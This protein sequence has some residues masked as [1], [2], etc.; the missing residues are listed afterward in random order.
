M[1]DGSVPGGE[2]RTQTGVRNGSGP[3]L[4]PVVSTRER[5]RLGLSI[6]VAGC[7]LSDHAG[8]LERIEA[9]GYTDLWTQETDGH[10]A[11]T[12]LAFA[13]ARTRQV[14]LGSAIAS[15]STRGPALLAMQAAALADA[16]PGRF[17]LGIGTSSPTIVSGWNGLPFER[18]VAR[19]RATLRFLRRT[20][21]GE[22]VDFDEGDV[23]VRGFRLERP[24]APP[25]P[26]FLAAL[27]PQMLGL[28]AR[29]A[30]GVL[31]SLVGPDDVAKIRAARVAANPAARDHELA[32][33][34]G[35]LVDPD[36]D[37]ARARCRRLIAAYLTIG[38]YAA[39]HRRL[40]RGALLDP[41]ARAWQQGDRARAVSLVPD[42]LVDALF[43]HGD[44]ETC[45][46]GLARFRAA[47][48]DTPIVS[49]MSW[50]GRLD[51]V[52]TGLAEDA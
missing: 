32:L 19:A 6:P 37:A 28:A 44:V 7:S 51:D 52:L 11:F 21:Q 15:I 26:I 22:R 8:L 47:G 2:Q 1:A 33:R 4:D 12:P 10:D 42:D 5:R 41:I 39:M 46:R 24:P 16:A 17:V 25:P 38:P 36:V 35:T 20:L 23:R 30:D 45:R 29:E 43:V 48:L 34:I 27:G 40:G 18:P 49:L 3:G 31:L 14:R 50:R 9:L 13:A